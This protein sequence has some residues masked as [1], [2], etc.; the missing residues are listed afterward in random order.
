MPFP[1]YKNKHNENSIFSP[2]DFVAYMSELGRYSD[3]KPPEG[4]I[5]CYTGNVIAYATANY[6]VTTVD[7]ISS[8]IHLFNETD[9]RVGI[10]GNFGIGAPMVIAIVEELIAL[11][12]KSFVSIGMAGTLQKDLKIGDIVVCD[13]AIR[14]EGTSH[15]YLK[16][17]KYAYASPE[18]TER[19]KQV[20][21]KQRV[22]YF[23]G[24]SWTIDTPYRET[25]AEAKQYQK[26]GIATVDMEASAL[27][28][29]SQYRGVQMGA[30][31]TISDSLA[32]LEF[33]PGFHLEATGKGLE[34][35]CR[36]AIEA[37]SG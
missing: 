24:T 18:M 30:I 35:L 10:I 3:F 2:A 4:V 21:E 13:R 7:G 14:D 34:I 8:G 22:D 27:F 31:F 25:V 32:S 36:V 19:I 23:T 17:S 37:L 26:E 33:S 1:N 15:H 12:A 28:A 20:L 16:P 29:I 11:G 5:L 9:N 6:T